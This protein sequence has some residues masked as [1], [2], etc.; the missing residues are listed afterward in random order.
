MVPG[1]WTPGADKEHGPEAPGAAQAEGTELGF[2]FLAL[3]GMCGS[4]V[5]VGSDAQALIER[6]RICM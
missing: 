3:V 1:T 6:H 4:V 5:G 2:V